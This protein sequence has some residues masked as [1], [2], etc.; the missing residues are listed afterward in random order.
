MPDQNYYKLWNDNGDVSFVIDVV[1]EELG[2]RGYTPK[3]LWKIANILKY[4]LRLGRKTKDI[5]SDVRKIE[6][7]QEMLEQS[8]KENVILGGE[9]VVYNT[10]NG[11]YDLSIDDS[12]CSCGK[13][14]KCDC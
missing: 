7:Y 11:E 10:K 2:K 1:T 6:D 9:E 4:Q 3:Q 13:G 12:K 5:E 8:E 14:E